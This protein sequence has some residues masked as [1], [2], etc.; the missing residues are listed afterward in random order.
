MHL[1]ENAD[2]DLIRGLSGQIL[3]EKPGSQSQWKKIAGDHFGDCVKLCMFSWWV[4]K[5][6]FPVENDA[7]E[8]EGE[9]DGGE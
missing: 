9:R 3:E 4:L 2:P 6:S 8:E 1:P 7:A 5:S